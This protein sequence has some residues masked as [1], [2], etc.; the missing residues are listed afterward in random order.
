MSFESSRTNE[1]SEEEKIREVADDALVGI[2]NAWEN[3]AEDPDGLPLSSDFSYQDI[4]KQL[5][6]H[7]RA[8]GEAL[9]RMAR[10][11]TGKERGR[12]ADGFSHFLDIVRKDIAD[13]VLEGMLTNRET[14]RE[15]RRKAREEE[16]EKDW[17]ARP[18]SGNFLSRWWRNA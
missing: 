11:T 13:K 5:E 3:H 10:S 12:Y 14:A 8:Y 17:H 1:K 18:K 6:A 15:L 7:A 16:Q 9:F 2:E 4:Q